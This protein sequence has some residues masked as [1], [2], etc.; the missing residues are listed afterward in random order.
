MTMLHVKTVLNRRNDIG[1][2]NIGK[3]ASH[4]TH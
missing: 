1:V 4:D 2:K 3:T